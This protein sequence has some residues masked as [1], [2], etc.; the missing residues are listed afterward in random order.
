MGKQ[1]VYAIILVIMNERPSMPWGD[2]ERNQADRKS[3]SLEHNFTRFLKSS[4]RAVLM[5]DKLKLNGARPR[6][7]T[8]RRLCQKQ[9]AL[10]TLNVASK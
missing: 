10:K 5:S 8:S 9:A 2:S 7:P 6:V 1:N 3:S 4:T